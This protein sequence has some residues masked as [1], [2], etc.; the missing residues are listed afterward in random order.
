MSNEEVYVLIRM[1][2]TEDKDILI[3]YLQEGEENG[4]VYGDI[5]D[6]LATWSFHGKLNLYEHVKSI[7]FGGK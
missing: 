2:S 4:D 1:Q 5:F 7:Q 3:N 6:D